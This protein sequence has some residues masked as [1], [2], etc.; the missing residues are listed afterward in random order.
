MN[1]LSQ[2]ELHALL[3]R[4]YEEVSAFRIDDHSFSDASDHSLCSIGAER[5]LV[6]GRVGGAGAAL[7]LGVVRRDV[8]D[9]R[10]FLVADFPEGAGAASDETEGKKKERAKHLMQL[11]PEEGCVESLLLLL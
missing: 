2:S 8:D 1:S 6:E 3:F 9:L 10:L 4:S 11:A 7:F 5:S